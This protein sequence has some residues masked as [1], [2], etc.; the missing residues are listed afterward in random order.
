MQAIRSL[1]YLTQ[2]CD[3]SRRKQARGASMAQERQLDA[4]KRS[5]LA[6]FNQQ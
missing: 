6:Q 5:Q 1:N 4:M 3:G 2:I